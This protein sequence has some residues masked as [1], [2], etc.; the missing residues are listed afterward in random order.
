MTA[1]DL[2]PMTDA[3]DAIQETG[4]DFACAMAAL[5][6]RP[7][8]V[9]DGLLAMVA[10]DVTRLMREHRDSPQDLLDALEALGRVIDCLDAERR[11]SVRRDTLIWPRLEVLSEEVEQYSLEQLRAGGL[12]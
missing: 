6:P 8:P 9:L 7:V 2:D 4:E 10:P 12:L 3:H 1:T 11:A 5:N